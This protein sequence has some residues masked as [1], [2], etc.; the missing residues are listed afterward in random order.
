MIKMTT[1]PV[2]SMWLE[3]CQNQDYFKGGQLKIPITGVF[4]T[5]HLAPVI[6]IVQ[7]KVTSV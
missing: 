3:R 1:Q 6:L 7:I 5:F 4:P 2:R